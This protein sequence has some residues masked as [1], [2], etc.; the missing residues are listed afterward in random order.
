MGSSRQLKIIMAGS[1]I[2]YT[3]I[4]PLVMVISHAMSKYNVAGHK[5]KEDLWAVFLT[6]FSVDM[7]PWSFAFAVLGGGAGYLYYKKKQADEAKTKLCNDLH[8]ALLEIKK[9]SGILN[10]CCECKK[11]RDDNGD[12]HQLESYISNNSEADFSHAYCPDCVQKPIN[13]FEEYKH[14]LNQR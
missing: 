2:S 6:S 10:I 8:I 4:H 3:C 13:E 1:F 5:M 12:W 14:R 9:L 11:I 7:L